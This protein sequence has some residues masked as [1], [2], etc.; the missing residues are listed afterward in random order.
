MLSAEKSANDSAQSP[1]CSRKPLPSATRAR[2]VR[3]VRASPANTSGGN[4][5]SSSSAAVSATASGH[6]G[7]W[8]AGKRC[9]LVGS[10]SR[11]G[12]DCADVIGLEVVARRASAR[13]GLE[14]PALAHLLK[15][16]LRL[17]LLGEQRGL[18]AV[19]QALEP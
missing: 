12:N 14:R 8:R 6:T 7:C 4:V 18:D 3:S 17:H 2:V 19:E 15:L 1:A 5:R 16:L 10:Q 11:F 9:Q 13:S